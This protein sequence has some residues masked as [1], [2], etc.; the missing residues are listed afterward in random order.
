MRDQ[1]SSAV[2]FA[3]DVKSHDVGQF[4]HDPVRL[5]IPQNGQGVEPAT[6]TQPG[7]EQI[8]LFNGADHRRIGAFEIPATSTEFDHVAC[9]DAAWRAMKKIMVD[10]SAKFR[11]RK[12]VIC[13]H[14]IL[15]FKTAFFANGL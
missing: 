9:R 1:E 8:A 3:D 13:P 4:V 7:V 5:I 6:R 10:D 12:R 15:D 11:N 2:V 14:Q